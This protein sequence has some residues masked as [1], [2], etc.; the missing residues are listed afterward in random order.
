[1]FSKLSVFS[2]LAFAFALFLPLV[3]T[4]THNTPQRRHGHA[5]LSHISLNT[6][7]STNRTLAARQDNARFTMYYQTGNDGACGILSSDNDFI[8]AL[9]SAQ[10]E[11]G[12][13]CFKMIEI[14]I[15]GK[16]AQAQI[17]DECPGCPWG[18]I[19]CTP[20]IAKFFG[21]FD[22]ERFGSWNLVGAAPT[23]TSKPPPPPTST[24]HKKSS[25]APPPPT[26]T[27]K[28]HTTSSSAWSASPT[29]SSVSLSARPTSPTSNSSA[30]SASANS[31]ASSV[32][33]SFPSSTPAASSA[34]PTSNIAQLD[35]NLVN[36]VLL[37]L[38][39]EQAK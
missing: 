35:A 22:D 7:L 13:W 21:F 25:A 23:T 32:L 10:Y 6:T 12:D 20:A 17:V 8:V 30:T 9:N 36:L 28:T 19:D 1:M 15:G 3:A 5:G 4:G 37:V 11:S 26:K 16:T 31:T 2:A 38:T 18:G 39:S 34:T 27:S 14:S 33:V 24:T 29:S